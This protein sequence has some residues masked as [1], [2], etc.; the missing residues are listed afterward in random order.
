MKK[1]ILDFG[2]KLSRTEL[3]Q[4]SGGNGS[5]ACYNSQNNCIQSGLSSS[6]AQSQLSHADDH[7]CCNGC[8]TASW[9]QA[10]NCNL[11]TPDDL[12]LIIVF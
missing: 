7:W 2:Q 8:G 4:I 1:Q 6:Q 9:N 3:Q 11:P 5:C 12:E 10:P